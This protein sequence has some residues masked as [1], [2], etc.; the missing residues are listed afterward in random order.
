MAVT[1]PRID[2]KIV[3]QLD[4]ILSSK[5]FRQ[6]DRL[7]RFLT[8]T[9]NETLAGRGEQ[10][11]EFVIGVEVFGKGPSFD[12]RNDP[13][14]RVQARRLRSQLARYYQEEGHEDETLI[15]L[16][17]GG[18]TPVFRAFRG[19]APKR[20][21][22]S[23][24]VSR[25]T[26]LLTP[27][28]DYS[29]VGTLKYFCDGLA[30]ELAHTL[31]SLGTIGVVSAACDNPAMILTGSVRQSGDDLRITVNLIDAVNGH[32]LASESFDRKLEN[33]F[34]IQS[35][36]ANAVAEKLRVRRP[37]GNLAARNLYAQG[38]YHLEQ[39]TEEGL[40]K[41]L[42]FFDRALGED[43]QFALAYSG[44]SDAYGLLGHYGVMPPEEVWTKAASNA[45]W[46]VLQDERSA[47]AHTSLAHVKSTQDW[48]W[49]GA[50]S[51]YQR[52]IALDP[53]YATAHHWY[54][55]SCLAPQGRLAEALEQILIA[56]EL[57]PI[58]SIIARDVAVVHYYRQD[59][60]AALDQCD[61][62]IE[63]NP[64]FP[65]AYWILGLVQEQRG[66][67]DESAAAFQ[68]A[69]QLSPQSPRMHAALGRTLALSGKKDEARRILTE[70][71]ELAARRY[72]SPSDVAS[73]HFALG[74]RDAGFEWLTKAFRDR[75]FEL[76]CLKVDPRLDAVRDDPRFE[77]LAAQLG[78][79]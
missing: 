53:R 42:E 45:A 37:S 27:F 31:T 30:E 11:K 58:S 25:N 43:A 19:V 5:A 60:G 23:A 68:R 40:R 10:L 21:E 69:I 67:F 70:L 75:C 65:P 9:V 46:A 7:K 17:K 29:P 32:Y 44:L 77:A 35:D 64:H 54:S 1:E 18:Y 16:P 13:I 28:A 36:V 56:H 59:L 50:E 14:V 8:F 22:P 48:D 55:V 76:L 78:L 57:D 2:E 39:R 12:P 79:D 4:R 24:L 34:A 71:R 15:E 66:D 74:D 52:A 49:A 26:I 38:R 41:A 61:H 3:A 63:L 72:V 73:L 51:E 6:A 20:I 62:N 33:V 47:E